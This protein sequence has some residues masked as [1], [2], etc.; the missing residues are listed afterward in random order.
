[1]LAN[2]WSDERSFR[3]V[4]GAAVFAKVVA[5][6]RTKMELKNLLTD[7]TGLKPRSTLSKSGLMMMY[8]PPYAKPTPQPSPRPTPQPPPA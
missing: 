1:M 3:V 7:L 8:S 4:V 2:Y 6:G 5:D